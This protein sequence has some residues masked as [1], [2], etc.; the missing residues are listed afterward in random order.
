M[1]TLINIR[2]DRTTIRGVQATNRVAIRNTLPCSAPRHLTMIWSVEAASGR[3][4]ARWETIG[5][6]SADASHD[7]AKPWRLLRPPLRSR[8]HNHERRT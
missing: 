4:V 7:E 3:P 2:N 8:Q 1:T 6:E 5:G